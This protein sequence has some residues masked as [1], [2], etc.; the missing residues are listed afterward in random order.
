[1][2]YNRIKT[3]L[4]E[5]HL[6]NLYLLYGNED[7]LIEKLIDRIM[8]LADE[9][10]GE[11]LERKQFERDLQAGELE[12][13]L[14]TNTFFGTGKIIICSDTGIFKDK[15]RSKAFEPLLSSITDDSYVIFREKDTDARVPLFTEMKKA[16]YAYKIEMRKSSEIMGYVSGRFRK[17]GK[18]ITGANL[19]LFVELAGT[20]LQ[21]IESDIEKILLY[22]GELKE[23]KRDYILKL[24]SGSTRHRVYE[25]TDAIFNK[26]GDKAHV[27]LKDLLS[28]KVPVQVLLASIHM[29]LMELMTVR[30]AMSK[31]DSPIIKRYNK[32]VQ[33][34]IIGILKKQAANFSERALRSFIKDAADLDYD[35]KSGR[36]AGETGLIV[37]VNEIIGV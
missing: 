1:M 29:R 30:E 10:A 23:V 21:D 3:E 4:G 31:G 27:L 32:P 12:M 35:I 7:Y 8:V 14:N 20:A 25:L 24:C 34:F 33:D 22:M 2:N 16:G 18:K 5:K 15:N 9:A 17:N 11:T 13:A 6:K 36:I 26:Q 37:L 28:D 19:N